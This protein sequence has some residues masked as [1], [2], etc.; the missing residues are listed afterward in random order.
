MVRISFPFARLAPRS[1]QKIRPAP[2]RRRALSRTSARFNPVG[3]SRSVVFFCGDPAD[4]VNRK[5]VYY[6]PYFIDPDLSALNAL[7]EYVYQ[8]AL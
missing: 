3:R 2:P 6:N 5:L 1:S 4:L 7:G 8:S